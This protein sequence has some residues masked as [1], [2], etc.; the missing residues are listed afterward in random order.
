M[1]SLKQFHKLF[2]FKR[3]STAKFK[4]CISAKSN[5]VSEQ[6]AFTVGEKGC[7]TGRMQ[8]QDMDE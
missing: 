5:L 8:V 1:N 2:I 3:Y 4:I 6:S 7:R